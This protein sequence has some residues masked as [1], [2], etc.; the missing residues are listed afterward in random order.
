[1][2]TVIKF[3]IYLTDMGLK[4]LLISCALLFPTSWNPDTYNNSLK[5]FDKIENIQQ[6][7]KEWIYVCLEPDS[8]TSSTHTKVL[9]SI[10]DPKNIVVEYPISQL[11]L[12]YKQEQKFPWWKYYKYTWPQ[13]PLVR[14]EGKKAVWRNFKALLW[15]LWI[16]ELIELG[17]H[18]KLSPR[19]NKVTSDTEYQIW[20]TLNVPLINPFL[21]WVF[22]KYLS[23]QLKEEWFQTYSDDDSAEITRR[24]ENKNN[25]WIKKKSDFIYDIV[26]KPLSSWTHALALYKDGELFM[27]C[28]VSVWRNIIN[29]KGNNSKTITWQHKITAENQ[30]YW[31]ITHDSPMPNALNFHKNL[32]LFL[33]QWIVVK[34]SKSH[35]WKPASSWCIRTPWV[36]SDILH[37]LVY[38]LIRKGKCPDLFIH[39][40][41]YLEKYPKNPHSKNLNKQQNKPRP[42]IPEKINGQHANIQKIYINNDQN[43]PRSKI[44]R[45]LEN[46][47]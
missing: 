15:E 3:M 20:D 16:E 12:N 35:W 26:V 17:I 21:K 1:M 13:H 19:K 30:Y 39:K 7:T 28:A 33:H 4:N 2:I 31:S 45:N 24:I 47:A 38:P 9:E 34:D 46:V 10:T 22:P 27:T 29:S 36:N 14:K 44:F 23:D 11:F 5:N 18:Q 37:S 32:W 41:L 25:K 8:K 42:K 6:P 43:K 40:N